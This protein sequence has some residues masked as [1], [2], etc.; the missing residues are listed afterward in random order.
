[1]SV[2]AS[3]V[4][5]CS[6]LVGRWRVAGGGRQLSYREENLT[7]VSAT[8]PKFPKKVSFIRISFS[9]FAVSVLFGCQFAIAAYTTYIG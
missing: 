4:A 6:E 2:Y 5:L 3:H 8:V 9:Q 7:F 1:M